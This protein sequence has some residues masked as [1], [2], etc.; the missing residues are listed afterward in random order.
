MTDKVF[1]SNGDYMNC[2]GCKYWLQ[3]PHDGEDICLKSQYGDGLHLVIPPTGSWDAPEW[4][5]LRQKADL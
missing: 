2:N 3:L 5:P 4:C 1:N